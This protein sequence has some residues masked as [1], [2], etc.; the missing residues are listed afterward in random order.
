MSGRCTTERVQPSL[1]RKRARF[2][3]C[4]EAAG[5]QGQRLR[6][7]TIDFGRAS[8]PP[9][10]TEHIG[11]LISPQYVRGLLQGALFGDFA[12]AGPQAQREAL[13]AI[14]NMRA[15]HLDRV[16]LETI[17]VGRGK[18]LVAYLFGVF[19]Q[20]ALVVVH[21]GKPRSSILAVTLFSFALTLSMVAILQ[22]SQP[23]H[24]PYA[25]SL[26]PIRAAIESAQ[27]P[28][29]I[30]LPEPG[31]AEQGPAASEPR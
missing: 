31:G 2:C 1:A 14:K 13:D 4:A 12:K 5:P 15:G 27:K 24:G 3:C 18:W 23:F 29:E 9:D 16:L 6:D 11:H 17:T 22:F 26:R 7:L 30:S 21:L 25:V 20:I 19:T 10:W 28:S 8:T